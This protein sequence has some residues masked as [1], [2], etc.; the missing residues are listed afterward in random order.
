MAGDS[1]TCDLSVAD[2]T[3][4]KL[5]SGV[6]SIVAPRCQL[7]GG[8]GLSCGKP[9]GTTCVSANPKAYG[10]CLNQADIDTYIVYNMQ[11]YNS[12]SGFNFVAANQNDCNNSIQERHRYSTGS[13][14]KSSVSCKVGGGCGISCGKPNGTSCLS[15]NP[16]VMGACYGYDEFKN[17]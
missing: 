1:S 10:A 5:S 3:R 2:F 9:N 8:C 16:N 4:S 17:L 13:N 12:R 14:T 11:A 15:A 7:G 6:M